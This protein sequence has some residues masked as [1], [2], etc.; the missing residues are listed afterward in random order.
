MPSYTDPS[1]GFGIA[2]REHFSRSLVVRRGVLIWVK[3][4]QAENL[5]LYLAEREAGFDRYHALRAG[6]L[7][8]RKPI[9]CHERSLLLGQHAPAPTEHGHSAGAGKSSAG[10]CFCWIQKHSGHTP[11]DNGLPALR[12]K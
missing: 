5:T 4:T 1:L 3:V 10:R 12:A 7:M 2:A 11:R 8:F 6:A 9:I